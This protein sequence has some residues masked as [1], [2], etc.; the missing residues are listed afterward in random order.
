MP[1]LLDSFDP[2]GDTF[3]PNK[4]MPSAA[5]R[6]TAGGNYRLNGRDTSKLCQLSLSILND[7]V[8]PIQFI[9]MIGH[10]NPIVK[11]G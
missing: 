10:S 1:I 4:Q 9:L 6:V 2:L 3:D 8:I 11:N 5:L 7:S